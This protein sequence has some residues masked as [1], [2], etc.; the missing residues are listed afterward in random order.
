V[1]DEPRK[2]SVGKIVVGSEINRDAI[3]ILGQSIYPI[4]NNIGVGILA[5]ER[6]GTL[7]RLIESIKN[8]TDLNRTTVFIS[9]D[10]SENQEML[11]YLGVLEQDDRFVVIRNQRRLGVAGN[12]NRILRA[13]SRFRYGLILNDDIEILKDGWEHLYVN[14]M[15]KTGYNH[16]V[17]RKSGVYDADLGTKTIVED[18]SLNVVKEKPH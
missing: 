10:G 12:S 15:N 13:L 8:N 3:E 1:V 6:A 17:F 7:K 4:S 2:K 16:L 11:D 5:Y 18:V 14:A 9:D